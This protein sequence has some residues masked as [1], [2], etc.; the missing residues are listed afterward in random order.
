MVTFEISFSFSAVNCHNLSLS[1]FLDLASC[2]SPGNR[3][4][5]HTHSQSRNRELNYSG[6]QSILVSKSAN[7]KE[8]F[9]TSWLHKIIDKGVSVLPF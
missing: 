5:T 4:W 8:N 7:S 3:Q 2:L 6:S 1:D 9:M